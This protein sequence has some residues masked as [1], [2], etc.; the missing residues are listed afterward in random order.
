MP[1]RV[2]KPFF[3]SHWNVK[4]VL[5]LMIKYLCPIFKSNHKKIN[6][7]LVNQQ[8][9][10]TFLAAALSQG[11]RISFRHRNTPPYETLF[12]P[13]TVHPLACLQASSNWLVCFFG[14]KNFIFDPLDNSAT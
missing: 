9:T 8:R 7:Y 14:L 13:Q 5:L 12:T 4:S 10:G 1:W 6:H 11:D 3:C 2:I